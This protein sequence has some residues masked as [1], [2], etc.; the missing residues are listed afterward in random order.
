MFNTAPLSKL[1]N[2]WVAGAVGL[3][4]LAALGVGPVIYRQHSEANAKAQAA[5]DALRLQ[6]LAAAARIHDR[7]VIASHEAARAAHDDAVAAH[8]SAV[9]VFATLDAADAKAVKDSATIKT[10]VNATAYT[11][12]DEVAIQTRDAADAVAQ[13]SYDTV[14]G[15]WANQPADAAWL[16]KSPAARAKEQAAAQKAADA[17]YDAEYAGYTKRR[18]PAAANLHRVRAAA[19]S[20][21][22]EVAEVAYTYATTTWRA[23]DAAF[24]TGAVSRAPVPVTGQTPPAEPAR[25]C[26]AAT[27]AALAANDASPTGR[28]LARAQAAETT[29]ARKYGDTAAAARNDASPTGIAVSKAQAANDASPTGVALRAATD[30]LGTDNAWQVGL[31]GKHANAA[32]P[33]AST[34]SNAGWTYEGSPTWANE[35]AWSRARGNNTL[36]PTGS[37]ALLAADGAAAGPAGI[38]YWIA[39]ALNDASPTGVA[40]SKAWVANFASPTRRAYAALNRRY[41]GVEVITRPA[42]TTTDARGGTRHYAAT[43]TIPYTDRDDAINTAQVANDASPT[44]ATVMKASCR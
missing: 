43:T 29:A 42:Y 39:A 5:S 38:T 21:G 16:A 35:T 13:S 6:S 41:R 36:S 12:S 37:A 14:W 8:A 9:K 18:A 2:K 27:K 30:A 7:A 1:R 19:I 10:W 44:R 26:V 34:A 11:I 28:A 17:A 15:A 20:A 33:T 32:S 24:G 4:V 3:A 40:V 22:R 23:A 25:S 31:S